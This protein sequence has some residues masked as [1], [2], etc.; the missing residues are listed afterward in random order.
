MKRNF[1]IIGSAAFVALFLWALLVVGDTSAVRGVQSA[2]GFAPCDDK[3]SV[4]KLKSEPGNKHQR[5]S[6]KTLVFGD[7]E[8]PVPISGVTPLKCS[9]QHFK[10]QSVNYDIAFLEFDDTGEL[11]E[12]AQQTALNN[13]LAKSVAENEVL[14]V[15]LFVHGWRHDAAIGD[16]DV[17]HFHTMTS[18]TANYVAQR[19]APTAGTAKTLGI[20]MGW[21]GKLLRE[22]SPDW[23]AN[24]WAALTILNRK[25][26]SDEIALKMGEEIL[27]I[28]ESV[29][30]NDPI[31][32]DQKLIIYGHSLGGNIVLKGLT[33]KL[34]ERIAAALPGNKPIQGIGDL[35]VLFNPASEATNFASLQAQ[36]L[37]HQGVPGQPPVLVSVTAAK[38]YKE[39]TCESNRWDTAVGLFFPLMQKARHFCLPTTR[40]SL[41]SIGNHLPVVK[42]NVGGK[43]LDDV[44]KLGVSHEIEF[45][46]TQSE[47]TSYTLAG[48]RDPKQ[49]VPWCPP[50]KKFMKWQAVA[51]AAER[52]R[53]GTDGWDN[54]S[55]KSGPRDSQGKAT[56]NLDSLWLLDV[57]AKSAD[58]PPS[59]FV[60]IR[61]GAARQRCVNNKS[62]AKSID[63]C[64]RVLADS[65][66]PND[67]AQ[68]Y[69]IP[70]LG[71]PWTPVWN[72]ATH[73]DVIDEHSGYLSHSL[74]C[75]LNRF[76]LDKPPGSGITAKTDN[77]E[78][79]AN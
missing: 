24:G 4:M 63:L 68:H 43:A 41:N 16:E 6:E 2:A 71:S 74:W 47:P 31:K 53:R 18:L 66:L 1:L 77:H 72:V 32:R 22:P 69:Q 8:V 51:V 7:T 5:F 64:A 34:E 42:V 10:N 27:R 57:K 56:V 79:K 14:T 46:N 55:S 13:Y 19:P 60:N 28:E 38:Y 37:Q 39:L 54:E 73:S 11:R 45:D 65:N 35:V 12:P 26:T 58:D 61:H 50:E 20:Y 59:V 9:I 40:E 52:G 48:S 23:L 3:A 67:P 17:G 36:S 25:P 21:R 33:A 75:V 29:K 70:V 44:P 49:G 30:G 78:R 62:G 15:L 76:A